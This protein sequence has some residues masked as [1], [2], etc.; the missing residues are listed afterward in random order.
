MT[1]NPAAP[2]TGV[3]TTMLVMV[4]LLWGVS[5]PLTKNWQQ[6]AEACPGGPIVAI[7]HPVVGSAVDWLEAT[8]DIGETSAPPPPTRAPAPAGAASPWSALGS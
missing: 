1:A 6:A 2:G 8:L 3:P 4:T 7:G 5:F